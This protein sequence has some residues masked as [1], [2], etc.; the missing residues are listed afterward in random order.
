MKK[1]ITLVVLLNIFLLITCEYALAE[2][3]QTIE[4]TGTGTVTLAPDIAYLT[5]GI[6]TSNKTLSDG[7]A[8]NTKAS[9]SAKKAIIE[10]GISESD[11]ETTT[12]SIYS[13]PSDYNSLNSNEYIYNIFNGFKIT[14]RNI[15]DLN[16]I[17]NACVQNGANT[18]TSIDFNST[19]KEKAADQAREIAV[20]D[21]ISKAQKIADQ[22]GVKLDHIDSV[23][24][25][26]Q[27]QT[28][29]SFNAGSYGKGGTAQISASPVSVTVSV[30][31]KYIYKME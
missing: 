7:I 19:E 17:L 29:D 24:L 18:I 5:A 23:T 20:K 21:A 16:K 31:I 22:I 15:N 28:N 30:T 27:D 14:I 3:I 12:Y 8:E 4:T 9:D 1:K 25:N 26:N 10:A 2:S 6:S 11:I 13:N